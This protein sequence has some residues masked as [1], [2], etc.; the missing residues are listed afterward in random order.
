MDPPPSGGQDKFPDEL[1]KPPSMGNFRVPLRG[2]SGRHRHTQSSAA[3]LHRSAYS[4]GSLGSAIQ[5]EY[6]RGGKFMP[7]PPPSIDEDG[8]SPTNN[9]RLE[10]PR[11]QANSPR[12]FSAL[13]PPAGGKSKFSLDLEAA[14]NQPVADEDTLVKK[15]LVNKFAQ[16][17]MRSYP[18]ELAATVGLPSKGKN[19]NSPSHRRAKSSFLLDDLDL[20]NWADAEES[21]LEM[22]LTSNLR[23][24]RASAATSLEAERRTKAQSPSGSSHTSPQKESQELEAE[25]INALESE[26]KGLRLDRQ[27]LEVKYARLKEKNSTLME[28]MRGVKDELENMR[29]NPAVA[30]ERHRRDSLANTSGDLSSMAAAAARQEDSEAS[31]AK[32][33]ALEADVQEKCLALKSVRKQFVD[34]LIKQQRA[35]KT[36]AELEKEQEEKNKLCD[37][38][39]EKIKQLEQ[40]L[41]ASEAKNAKLQANSENMQRQSNNTALVKEMGKM[42]KEAIEKST[43]KSTQVETA[44]NNGSDVSVETKD[45]FKCVTCSYINASIRLVCHNCGSKRFAD[46]RNEKERKHIRKQWVN[47]L[48]NMYLNML[49]EILKTPRGMKVVQGEAKHSCKSGAITDREIRG[50]EEKIQRMLQAAAT[51]KGRQKFSEVYPKLEDGSTP[52]SSGAKMKRYVKSVVSANR[53]TS[54]M[55]KKLDALAPG[56]LV[57]AKWY[58]PEREKYPDWYEAEVAKV[59][60]ADSYVIKYQNGTLCGGVPRKDIRPRRTA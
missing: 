49:E 36:N 32:I 18:P 58:G 59:E 9:G 53:A 13:P 21:E 17:I 1:A 37:E 41:A 38:Y 27:K 22:Q 23:S 31:A 16:E 10:S 50:A 4:T 25:L 2:R 54:G 8:E 7:L 40:A 5:R 6:A 14:E 15:R 30:E 48:V 45:M 28:Q 52:E 33:A 42:L 26:I 43:K 3:V 46:L 44:L 29:K 35:E 20:Y 12:R 19:A 56:T 51:Q 47:S 11:S 57:Y 34:V 24:L 55:E 60:D 39:E